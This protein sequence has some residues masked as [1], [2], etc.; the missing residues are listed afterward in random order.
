MDSIAIE[1]MLDSG[2]LQSVNSGNVEDYLAREGLGVL[3]FAGGNKQRSDAHDVAVALR[4][5]LKDYRGLVHAG[6][7]ADDHSAQLQPRF[8][9]LVCPSLVLVHGGE[10]LEVIPRVRDWADYARA[11][12]RY[13]GNPG[14]TTMEAH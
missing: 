1:D 4:E 9:V 13:L 14:Q 6:L 2:L 10:T 12:Q 7:V 5:I 8:R 3:F 11:F